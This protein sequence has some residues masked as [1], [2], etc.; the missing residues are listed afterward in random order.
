VKKTHNK[1]YYYYN[2]QH[3]CS[4]SFD[5]C[6]VQC[7]ISILS[8]GILLKLRTNILPWEWALLKRFSR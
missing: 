1:G 7:I 6:Y 2:R 8:G 5:T 4:S 3:V